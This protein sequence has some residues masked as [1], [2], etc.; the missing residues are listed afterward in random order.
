MVRCNVNPPLLTEGG[1]PQPARAVEHQLTNAAV[2]C[3]NSRALAATSCSGLTVSSCC[4][5]VRA[6]VTGEEQK[7]T[8]EEVIKTVDASGEL[9][10]KVVTEVV[11]F[12]EFFR[13]EEY[14]Q[15]YLVKNHGG[16]TCHYIRRLN[17]GEL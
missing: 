12:R 13:A 5:T 4:Q 2:S 14:H 8:A 16:Y 11:P 7:L 17:L 3:N 15:K 9:Q 6:S 1:S 10:V